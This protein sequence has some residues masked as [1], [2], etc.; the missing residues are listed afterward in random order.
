MR[1]K[2]VVA[3]PREL[4]PVSAI[5][6]TL[7]ASSLAGVRSRELT[8]AY[9]E[10]LAPE[11]HEAAR[12]LVPLSWVPVGFAAAHYAVMDALIPDPDEQ[13]Q[14]GRAT[15]NRVQQSYL[16]T[17]I[18]ALRASGQVTPL[19]LLTRIDKVWERSFQGGAAAVWQ[20]GP[21]DARVECHG[22]SLVRFAYVRN[23]WQGVFEGSVGLVSR[24]AYVRQLPRR[25]DATTMAF[26][27]SWV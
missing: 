4:R 16:R 7:I 15:A 18:T 11:H 27:V 1:E 20:V 8:D 5:R 3:L 13:V 10:R 2:V 22:I 17:L 21:K 23:G 25:A 6:G 14:L 19:S 9:Y 24:T 12:G 26:D